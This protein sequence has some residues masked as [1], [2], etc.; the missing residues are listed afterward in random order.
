MKLDTLTSQLSGLRTKLRPLLKHHLFI[1]TIALLSFLIFMVYHVSQVLQQ[2]PDA[3]Y[4]EQK[5]QTSIQTS[6]DQNTIKAI[7]DVLRSR[8]QAGGAITYDVPQSARTNPFV[9]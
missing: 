2:P 8:D 7:N 9:P 4:E 1:T 3:T 5:Q 6:F